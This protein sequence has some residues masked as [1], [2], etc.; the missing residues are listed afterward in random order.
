MV[1]EIQIEVVIS[2]W[3]QPYLMAL[4]FFCTITGLEPDEERLERI[5]MSALRVRSKPSPNNRAR[6]GPHKGESP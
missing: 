3:L 1:N 4:M 5:V 6:S 2:W